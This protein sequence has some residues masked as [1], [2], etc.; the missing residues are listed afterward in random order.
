MNEKEIK[1][2]QKID[3]EVAILIEENKEY[4]WLIGA[5]HYQRK[6]MKR[7]G[8]LWTKKQQNYLSDLEHA[9]QEAGLDIPRE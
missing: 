6:L 8:D 1:R 3:D 9:A 2:S 4:S 7:I 5:L